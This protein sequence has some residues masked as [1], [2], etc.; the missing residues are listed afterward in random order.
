MS[1]PKRSQLRKSRKFS[2]KHG[3]AMD[4]VSPNK[5]LFTLAVDSE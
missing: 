5:D 3:S 2:E 1:T 4:S